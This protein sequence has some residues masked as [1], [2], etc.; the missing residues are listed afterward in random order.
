ML[1]DLNSDF[2][3]LINCLTDRG[4]NFLVVG[5]HALAFQGVARQDYVAT[6]RAS[7]RPKDFSDVTLLRSMIG[8]L[9]GDETKEIPTEAP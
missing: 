7:G 5:A 4:V 2:Q 8:P 6:K 1:S 3:E 9:P